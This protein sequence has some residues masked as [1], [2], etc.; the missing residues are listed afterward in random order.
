V[1]TPR[2]ARDR[3]MPGMQRRLG[4]IRLGAALSLAGYALLFNPLPNHRVPW[5]VLPATLAI[6]GLVSLTA[7]AQIRG[8]FRAARVTVL[9]FVTLDIVATLSALALYSFDPR[10]YLF[11]FVL[12]V[13]AEGAILLGLRGGVVVWGVSTLGYVATEALTTATTGVSASVAGILVR[14]TT[15]LLFTAAAGSMVDR[16]RAESHTRTAEARFQALVEG[17]ADG[18]QLLDRRGTYLYLSPSIER[19]LGYQAEEL[20]GTN[21]FSL[22]HPDDV[23]DASRTLASVLE[24]PDGHGQSVVRVRHKDGGWRWV[25]GSVTNM[26]HNPDVGGLVV[27]FRDVTERI[28]ADEARGRLA[29]IVESSGDAI[30]GVT[31]HG[32]IESWNAGAERLY[33]YSAGEVIGR[34]NVILAPPHRA[35]EIVGLLEQIRAGERVENLETERRRRDGSVVPVS[36]T[37]SPIRDNAGRVVGASAIARDITERRKAEEAL[38]RSEERVSGLLQSAPDA[39]V[40]I[41]EGGRIT[42]VNEQ[43]EKMFGYD[44]DELRAQQVEVLLPKALRE[45]H[46]LHRRSYMADMRTRP[47]GV[48]LDLLAVRKD[49]S[50]F[51]V[52]IGLSSMQVPE[53][54]LITCII[55]DITERKRA[56][57]QV[58]FLAYHDKLTGLPNRAMLEE[59][60]DLAMARS[61]RQETA[62]AVLF[63][64]LDNFKLVNDSLGHAAG[65]ELLRETA[66]RLREAARETDVVARQGGDEFLFLLA[67]LDRSGGDWSEPVGTAEAVADRIHLALR[68]PFV[69][70]DAELYLSASIGVS[71]FPRDAGD[72]ASLL[73]NADLAMYASKRVGPGGSV[74]YSSDERD[75][76]SQLSLATG[77][78]KAAETGSWALQYQPLVDLRSGGVTGVEALVRWKAQGRGLVYPKDFLPAAEDMGLTGA[79]GEWVLEEMCRQSRAWSEA[80]LP[81]DVSMNLSPRQLQQPDLAGRILSRVEQWGVDPRTVIVELTESTAMMDLR[82]TERVL[83]ALREGGVRVAIDDFGTGYSSLSRLTHLPVEILKIDRSFVRYVLDDSNARTVVVAMIRLAHALGMDA[84]AEGVETEEQWRFLTEQGCPLGQGFLFSRPLDAE[85]LTGRLLLKDDLLALIH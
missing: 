45:V 26:I 4:L 69:I 76:R 47:M 14:L 18:I 60:L 9:G 7:L 34:S 52:E 28:R 11:M 31:I 35:G 75:P 38:R 10:R 59:F 54:V 77:L 57:E 15:T 73:R 13:Q 40:V 33:G 19:I 6:A 16:R 83:W 24:V 21:A 65:D 72:G 74:T 43:A 37:V 53:G 48:G 66:A 84:L 30:L 62:V 81:L 3:V 5:H 79:I 8:G 42:L 82:R 20:I 41:D 17:A 46:V 51:P 36:L 85:E 78:R 50:E 68:Q 27:N 1:G 71:V 49:G 12:L 25:E 80:G 56:E 67:D 55:S 64:D 2:D 32:V 29:S 61:R 44:A 39:I 63:L 22:V 23:E 58:S 70:G